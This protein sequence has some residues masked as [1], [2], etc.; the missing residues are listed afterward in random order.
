ME[1]GQR[2]A[3]CFYTAGGVRNSSIKVDRNIPHSY[4]YRGKKCQIFT[5]ILILLL[6][7]A[8]P[9]RTGELFR[10]SKK[11]L[12]RTDGGCIS[13][14]QPGGGWVLP[15]QR[16]DGTKGTPKWAPKGKMVKLL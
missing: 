6:F 16:S 11:Q 14:Y 9:F 12:S 2:D 4:F 15:T 10:K 5:H 13:Q 3:H 7:G 1:N 8:T